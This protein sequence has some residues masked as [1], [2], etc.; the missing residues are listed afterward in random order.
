[1]SGIEEYSN[2]KEVD[3]ISYYVMKFYQCYYCS[4]NDRCVYAWDPYNKEKT[5]EEASLNWQCLATK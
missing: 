2:I 1:M 5:E 3:E 4:D